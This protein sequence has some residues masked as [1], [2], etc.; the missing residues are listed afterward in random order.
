VGI[1]TDSSAAGS[2]VVAVTSGTCALCVGSSCSGGGAAVARVVGVE[3]GA[4][5][6]LDGLGLCVLRVGDAV[7]VL[8]IVVSGGSGVGVG[9]GGVGVIV[10]VVWGGH[11][12]PTSQ[13]STRG[14]S[15]AVA[16]AVAPVPTNGRTPRPVNPRASTMAETAVV[17]LRATCALRATLTPR[18][19]EY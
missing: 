11:S 8:V 2:S 19:R 12:S 6:V 18:S 16:A 3:A 17:R 9:V 10:T 14:G 15:A 5:V 4:S 13:G 7:T 1:W